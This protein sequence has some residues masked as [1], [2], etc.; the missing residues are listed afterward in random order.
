MFVHCTLAQVRGAIVM[1]YVSMFAQCMFV[2]S[3]RMIAPV[4]ICVCVCC[5]QHF[6]LGQQQNRSSVVMLRASLLLLPSAPGSDTLAP[7]FNSALPKGKRKKRGTRRLTQS[8]APRR[9]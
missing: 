6:R 3:Q 5:L 4:V 9:T 8:R 2:H 7:C 1:F